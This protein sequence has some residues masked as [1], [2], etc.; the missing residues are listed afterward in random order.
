MSTHIRAIAAKP[1]PLAASFAPLLW[2]AATCD[3]SFRMIA[4]W[5]QSPPVSVPAVQL[6]RDAGFDAAG[7]RISNPH[8][9]R[10]E[11]GFPEIFLEKFEI[12]LGPM[13]DLM[14]QHHD[15]LVALI[16]TA[17]HS[18]FL[19]KTLEITL[20]VMR[21]IRMRIQQDAVAANPADAWAEDHPEGEVL[22]LVTWKDNSEF[23]IVN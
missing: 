21:C 5:A 1:S 22:R 2:L 12:L 13:S 8:H 7:A 15:F 19:E 10:L 6:R 20:A 18:S 11:P 4:Q 23:H 17:V 9:G 14:R 3:C 16:Q